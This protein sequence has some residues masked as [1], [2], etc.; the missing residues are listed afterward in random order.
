[1]VEE[2]EKFKR[3]QARVKKIRGFYSNVITF[4]LVNI[5]LLIINLIFNPRNLWFYWV[6][7][8]W[9]LVLLIQAINIFTIRDRFLGEEWEKKKIQDLI[10][11]DKNDKSKDEHD[12]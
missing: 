7:I 10:K 11:K 9:G 6:T 4:V 8:I 1:M 5:L 12:V 2:D 3:A